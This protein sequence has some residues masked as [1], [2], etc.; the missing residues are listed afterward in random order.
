MFAHK[1]SNKFEHSVCVFEHQFSLEQIARDVLQEVKYRHKT[2]VSRMFQHDI[3]EFGKLD[4]SFVGVLKA[5]TKHDVTG[6]VGDARFQQFFQ[7]DWFPIIVANFLNKYLNFFLDFGYQAGSA[8]PK[9]FKGFHCK[10]SLLSPT[11]PR[12]TN[13]TLTAIKWCHI[14]AHL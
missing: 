13:N 14:Y 7:I 10:C 4:E 3:K 11:V 8:N 2:G 1:F 6:D 9:T 12:T 5:A